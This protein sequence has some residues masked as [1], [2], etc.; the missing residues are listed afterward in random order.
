MLVLS[1][2]SGEQVLIGKEIVVT[3]LEVRG[4]RVKLGFLGPGEVP[5]NRKEIER[6]SACRTIRSDAPDWPVRH[7]AVIGPHI[8]RLVRVLVFRATLVSSFWE[9]S[10]VEAIC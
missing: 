5:I 3:V 2:R 7:R 8:L 1:R 6:K 4:G 9:V 10:N